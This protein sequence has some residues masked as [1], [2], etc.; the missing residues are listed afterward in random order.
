MNGLSSR[1]LILMIKIGLGLVVIPSDE[2][3][4]I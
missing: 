1:L 3:Q 4:F 2:K